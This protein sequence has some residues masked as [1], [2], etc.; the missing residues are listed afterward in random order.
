VDKEIFIPHVGENEYAAAPLGIGEKHGHT[1]GNE[2]FEPDVSKD[3]AATC[4]QTYSCDNPTTRNQYST[5]TAQKVYK[6]VW[7]YFKCGAGW[8]TNALTNIGLATRDLNT[9]YKDIGYQFNSYYSEYTCK[10][11]GT[12]DMNNFDPNMVYQAISREKGAAFQSTGNMFIVVGQ[13]S[14]DTL[15]G[16]FV[17][18]GSSY[19]GTGFMHT[20]VVAKG[21]STLAHE[22]GHGFGLQHT[23]RGI[24]EVGCADG[25]FESTASDLTGDYC[26]DTPPVVRN[27]ECSSPLVN[28]ADTCNTKATWNPNPYQNISKHFNSI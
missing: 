11:T 28:T 17:L 23:F 8:E 9:Y 20:R 26:Q 2:L 3:T 6:I 1:C 12:T 4:S 13:P 19:S 14:D 5:S 7:L 22:I 25:C 24:S 21:Y 15:N 10:G 18:P 27:W 16:F